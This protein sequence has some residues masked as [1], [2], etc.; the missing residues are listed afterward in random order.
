L[1]F[2]SL[3]ETGHTHLAVL[4]A[5]CILPAAYYYF[6]IVAM[7]WT[8]EAGKPEP[9][10]LTP[11]QKFTLTATAVVTLVAGIFPEQFLQF[12]KYSILPRLGL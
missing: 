7:M 8:R 3:I 11:A 12:A 1:I 5:L 9:L 2:W 4:A 6:R 10:L